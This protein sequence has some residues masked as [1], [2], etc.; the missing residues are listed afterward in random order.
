MRKTVGMDR[1]ALEDAFAEFLQEKRLNL[2]QIDFVKRI[3]DYLAKN[4]EM[5]PQD[6]KKPAFACMSN[7]AVLFKGNIGDVTSIFDKVKEVT[8]NGSEIA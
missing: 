8:S 3:I 4:G 5:I 2:R 6:V 7:V 1:A